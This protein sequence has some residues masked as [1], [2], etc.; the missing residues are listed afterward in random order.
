MERLEWSDPSLLREI[1]LADM[2][3][4]YVA[5][6]A[7]ALANKNARTAWALLTQGAAYDRDH[8]ESLTAV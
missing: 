4:R 8:G 7:A 3:D 1:T 2:I 6:A 5:E